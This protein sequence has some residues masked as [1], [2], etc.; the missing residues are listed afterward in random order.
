LVICGIIQ[1][2]RYFAEQV[3]PAVDG[4]RVRY[5]GSVGPSRRAEILGS[6]LALLHPIRFA[7][8]FGLSVVESM[9]C[10]TPV[11]AYPRGSM[12]E[13]VDHGRTGFLV[14]TA[15]AAAATVAAAAGLDRAEC[16]RIAERRFSARRMIHDYLALY[17][18]LL[19]GR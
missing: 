11:I 16:R 9:A 17:G 7:E 15:E 12:R 3:E 2:Q 4:D 13:I 5:L 14:D 6:S 1:D 8:P 18:Q 10:G 19:G